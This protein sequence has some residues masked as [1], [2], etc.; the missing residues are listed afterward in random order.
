VKLLLKIYECVHYVPM[1]ITPSLFIRFKHMSND[2]N[3]EGVSYEL[4]W[5]VS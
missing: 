3:V 1:A 5:E 4:V 2:W